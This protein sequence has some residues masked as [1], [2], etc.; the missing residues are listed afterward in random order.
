[1]VYPALNPCWPKHWLSALCSTFLAFCLLNNSASCQLEGRIQPPPGDVRTNAKDGQRYVWV[2]AGA[3]QMGC[4]LPQAGATKP[5][6][7]AATGPPHPPRRFHGINICLDDEKPIHEVTISK[8]FWIGRKEVTVGAYTRFAR[9]TGTPFPPDRDF[10]GRKLNAVGGDPV[11]GM[12]W[13]EAVAY[14]G[15]AGLR[16]PTEAEWEYAATQR[17]YNGIGPIPVERKTLSIAFDLPDMGRHREWTAD[18]YEPTYYAAADPIDPKGPANGGYRVL[19]G[20]SEGRNPGGIRV[21][22]RY[23]YTPGTGVGSIRCAGE[24]Q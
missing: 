12:I 9:A 4:S 13:N 11:E 16:L 17:R 21:S 22:A 24:F 10:P 14:C 8:G 15:W 23:G 1:M 5:S 18:W 2:P 6:E 20:G 7:G 3:F 19:R